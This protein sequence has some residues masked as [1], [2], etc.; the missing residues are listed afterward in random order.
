MVPKVVPEV[1]G[2]VKAMQKSPKRVQKRWGPAHP[3]HFGGKVV[4]REV[5]RGPKRAPKSMK[6]SVKNSVDLQIYF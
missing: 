6:K 1:P 2:A 5:P 3:Q 4:P